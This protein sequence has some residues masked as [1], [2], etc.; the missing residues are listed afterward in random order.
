MTCRL[1]TSGDV[2]MIACRIDEEAHAL[3]EQRR[4]E[5]ELELDAVAELL[6]LVEVEDEH[7]EG[8]VGCDWRGHGD[9]EHDEGDRLVE[10]GAAWFDANLDDEV[11]P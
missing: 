4:L 5:A 2:R 10:V 9:D 1:I 3:A 6:G 7:D 8:E 11:S